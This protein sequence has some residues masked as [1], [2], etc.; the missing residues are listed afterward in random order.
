MK[1]WF[2]DH[3]QGKI[4]L[5]LQVAG[6]NLDVIDK[7]FYSIEQSIGQLNNLICLSKC[8]FGK[9]TVTLSKQF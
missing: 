5:Y 1:Q 8:S 9:K 7:T 3:L 6:G 4:L 2:T